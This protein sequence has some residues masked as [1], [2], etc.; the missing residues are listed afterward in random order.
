MST[1]YKITIAGVS[2][3]VQKELPS[4]IK[5]KFPQVRFKELSVAADV[6]TIIVGAKEIA[7]AIYDY[8]KKRKKEPKLKTVS[9]TLSS[10]FE[11]QESIK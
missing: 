11:V 5:R 7:E 10:T 1:M 3:D 4:D 9:V 8:I 2:S 6:I